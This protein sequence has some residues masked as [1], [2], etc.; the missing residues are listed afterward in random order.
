[1]SNRTDKRVYFQIGDVERIEYP[2]STCGHGYYHFNPKGERIEK[3]NQMQHNCTHCNSVT[4]FTIP[5][6]ALRYKGR[7]FVD[8]Q[9]VRGLPVDE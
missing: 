9:T 2:C 8:W 3:H 1:M 5:Y 4:F 7:V 6:P